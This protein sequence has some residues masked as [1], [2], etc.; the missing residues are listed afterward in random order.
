MMG[1][2]DWRFAVEVLACDSS[3]GNYMHNSAHSD[4]DKS[5]GSSFCVFEGPPTRNELK[6]YNNPAQIFLYRAGSHINFDAE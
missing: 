5:R 4:T 6:L 3:R 2:W 1:F